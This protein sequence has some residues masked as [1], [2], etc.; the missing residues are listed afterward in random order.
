MN[1]IPYKDFVS[2]GENLVAGEQIRINHTDCPD[3]EDTKRRLYIKRTEDGNNLLAY[4]HNCG[5]SGY[6]AQTNFGYASTKKGTGST[7]TRKES[8]GGSGKSFYGSTIPSDYERKESSW[9]KRGRVWITKYGITSLEIEKYRLGWSEQRNAIL[10]PIYRKGVLLGI[11]HRTFEED[12]PKYVT[13]AI[14]NPLWW[15]SGDYSTTIMGATSGLCIVEDIVS[16]IKCSRFVPAIA[17]LG[18]NL[19]EECAAFISELNID[20][21]K[22]KLFL[23][24]DNR[25]IKLNQL[26]IKGILE[27]MGYT[28]TIIKQNKDPKECSD[29]QLRELLL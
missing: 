17:L 6:Y 11:Q 14:H 9:S 22:I 10:M 25:Q 18:A 16:G 29:N 2:H 1:Y 24:N 23:D 21:S 4:C 3:G 7:G 8:K 15:Y 20:K 27:Q 5:N 26:K 28:V 12:H 19:S 13:K